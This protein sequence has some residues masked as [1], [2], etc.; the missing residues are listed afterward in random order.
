MKCLAQKLLIVTCLFAAANAFG[1]EPP[2]LKPELEKMSQGAADRVPPEMLR[3]FA[4]GIAEVRDTGIEGKAANVGDPAPDATLYDSEG[5]KVE[6]SSLWAEGPVVLTFYR[7]GWCPYCNL[8]L[9]NL[10][11][12]VAALEGAGARVVAVAPELPEKVGET[13]AKHD[14]S[15][16]VLS[17]KHNALA[18]KLGI[19][20]KL[21]DVILPVYRDRLKLAEYNGDQAFELPLAATYVI[22]ADGVIRYAFLDADYAKRAE[23]RDVLAALK[24]L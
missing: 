22:D 8:Q 20:F 9:Q 13:V 14:L 23:P 12:S 5:D 6:F 11:K 24:K 4:Q 21:P 2:L 10:Q 7:G 15:F 3:M 16:L 1:E 17:D 18:K 19:V